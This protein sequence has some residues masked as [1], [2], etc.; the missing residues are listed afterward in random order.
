MLWGDLRWGPLVTGRVAWEAGGYVVGRGG[1]NARNPPGVLISGTV[2]RSGDLWLT[3]KVEAYL[4]LQVCLVGPPP[5]R[6]GSHQPDM[7]TM[8]LPSCSIP[9]CTLSGRQPPPHEAERDFPFLVGPREHCVPTEEGSPPVNL[10]I[11]NVCPIQVP[12]L[13]HNMFPYG[14]N[15]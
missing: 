9:P 5:G 6:W 13:F 1:V 14:R 2:S 3:T 10:P 11:G 8:A 15:G 4:G 7:G 12:T